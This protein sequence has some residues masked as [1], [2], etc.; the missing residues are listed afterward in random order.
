MTHVAICKIPSCAGWGHW[1]SGKN[2]CVPFMKV[3]TV[4]DVVELYERHKYVESPTS[5]KQFAESEAAVDVIDEEDSDDL[6][7]SVEADD[8]GT[9]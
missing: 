3:A 5:A 6:A 4:P 9:E 1:P 8:W 7:D 2:L